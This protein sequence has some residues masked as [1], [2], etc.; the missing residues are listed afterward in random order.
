[1]SEAIITKTQSLCL[2]CEETLEDLPMH[3]PA[4]PWSPVAL[5]YISS[6]AEKEPIY[7]PDLLAF[8]R[9]SETNEYMR[10]VLLDW[11]MEL[12][13]KFYLKRETYYLTVSHID[14]LLSSINISKQEFQLIG[15]SALYLSC[16]S[17]EINPPKLQEFI[18]VSDKAYTPAKVLS[19]EKNIL[20]ILKWQ[21]YPHTPYSS[22]N[23][24]LLEWDNF[25]SNT[26]ADYCQY[27]SCL[28]KDK[29]KQQDL[30]NMRLETFK[31]ENTYS[32]KR[33]REIVQVLDVCS[34]DYST[35]SFKTC[36]LVGAL[37]YIMVNRC[38][39]LTKYELLWWNTL[40]LGSTNT[41]G[42][43][44]VAE[45]GAEAVC[46]LLDTFLCKVL[47]IASIKPLVPAIQ[48]LNPY[49]GFRFCYKLPPVTKNTVNAQVLAS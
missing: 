1:M 14:R 41:L 3:A 25:I 28:T 22:L 34:L 17:E 12:C 26:F 9:Q 38:F 47:N 10:S 33:F 2:L 35:Y 21:I 49:L 31:S 5:D 13:S 36:V 4:S 27:V 6:L 20:K 24:V 29:I 18:K 7:F 8:T 44:E 45:I 32:Y 40:V 23:A 39:Y 16:K 46:F 15:I 30:L 37:V 11:I 43:Q 48:H 42:E 19:M